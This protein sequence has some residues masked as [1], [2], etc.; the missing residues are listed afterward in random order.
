[1]RNAKKIKRFICYLILIAVIVYICAPFIWTFITSI[2]IDKDIYTRTLTLDVK[3]WNFDRYISI[4]S[5]KE[6]MA[7]SVSN[8][9]DETLRSFK[10]GYLNSIIV[11]VG[12]TVVCL[13]FGLLSAYA[14]CR[15]KSKLINGLFVSIMITR[16]LP[17]IVLTVPFF[18]L[19]RNIGLMDSKIGLILVYTTFTLPMIV[20]IMEGFFETIPITIEQAALIDGCS[21]F[22]IIYKIILPLSLPALATS[23]I[24][25]FIGAWQEFLFALVFTTS[26]KS[27]TLPVALAEF[28]GR[29]GMDLGMTS[30]GAILA[31]IPVIILAFIAQKYIVKGLTAGSVK[32]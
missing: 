16:F 18:V 11:S 17:G 32:G 19:L 1:M 5:G 7:A 23:G 31:C 15:F 9:G 4:L 6:T 26:N 25:A 27:K 14:F 20:W 24:M 22:Q 28:F 21:R 12:V 2:K 13:F 3:N 29:Q 8:V 10:Y 30:T